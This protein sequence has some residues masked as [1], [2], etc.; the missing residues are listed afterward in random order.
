MN[1][2]ILPTGT[3]CR[4]C[5]I[6]LISE[7]PAAAA[8]DG[9]AVHQ[10][11]G[12]CQIDYFRHDRAGTLL[13][14]PRLT[15]SHDDTLT[16]WDMLRRDRKTRVEAAK[17]MGITV[18]ALDKA[19]ERGVKAGDPRAVWAPKSSQPYAMAWAYRAV[20]QRRRGWPRVLVA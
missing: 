5:G 19:I 6:P 3:V 10:G 8:P 15:M 7:G 12:L 18:A 13:D 20:E 16:D 1:R 14:F 11:R 17:I 2:T 9:F 4:D